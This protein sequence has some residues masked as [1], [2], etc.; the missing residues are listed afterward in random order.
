TGMSA[1][2]GLLKAA[3]YH[4]TGSDGELYPP[5]S[6]L[7]A[8]TGISC[9]TGYRPENLRP[10]TDQVVVGNA[11]SKSNPE[12]LAAQERGLRML[13]FP[14]TLS[15]FFLKDKQPLVVVGT[16]GKTTTT[17]LLAWVLESAG[18]HPGVL[19][20][21]WAKNF[22]GNYQLGKGKYFV[23]EGDEYD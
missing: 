16:H 5:V 20:G 9:S 12:V 22:N 17:S 2:A 18:L 3:G 15:E 19:I 1:V 14:Q 13:S 11:V 21:G 6:T 10:G 4:V 23:I 8:R 7:L